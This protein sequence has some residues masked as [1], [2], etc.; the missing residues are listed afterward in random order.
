MSVLATVI[1][2][3]DYAVILVPLM[4]WVG[5][6]GF[7]W[8]CSNAD[9]PRASLRSWRPVILLVACVAALLSVLAWRRTVR[10]ELNDKTRMV[11]AETRALESAAR[12]YSIDEEFESESESERWPAGGNREVIATL[13]KAR[14]DGKDPYLNRARL[15]LS[16]DGSAIDPWGRAYLMVVT[17]GKGMRVWSAGPDGM[18]DT[19]DDVPRDRGL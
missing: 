2:L 4:A 6:L 12:L 8:R 9:D 11:R 10:V 3:W 13:T 5:V 15:R 16:P 18:G 1:T 17:E 14:E 19:E 7:I